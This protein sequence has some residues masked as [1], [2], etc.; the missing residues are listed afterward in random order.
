[1]ENIEN[2]G[3]QE[4]K[5]SDLEKVSGG[6][7]KADFVKITG[8]VYVRRGPGLEYKD[9]GSLSSGTVVAY[10]GDTQ[11]DDRDVAWFKINYNGN[12]GW[13]SSKYSKRV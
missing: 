3:I 5:E 12:V 4:M 11:W 1:M 6:K 9:I 8:N 2:K 10:L 7:G 13:V